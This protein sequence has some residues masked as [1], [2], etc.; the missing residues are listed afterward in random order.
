MVNLFIIQ[1]AFAGGNASTW[2]TERM[3]I[4]FVLIFVA[5]GVSIMYVTRDKN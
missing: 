4:V 2:P 5:V 1:E 3:G